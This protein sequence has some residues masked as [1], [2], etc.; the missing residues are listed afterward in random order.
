MAPHTCHEDGDTL[1]S[2]HFLYLKAALSVFY[3]CYSNCWLMLYLLVK[4]KQQL[5]GYSL[6]SYSNHNKIFLRSQTVT[7]AVFFL[8]EGKRS[9]HGFHPVNTF[10]KEPKF[11]AE[12]QLCQSLKRIFLT[13]S[14]CLTVFFHMLFL[15][16]FF[17]FLCYMKTNQ[18]IMMIVFPV[19]RPYNTQKWCFKARID[20]MGGSSEV[21]TCLTLQKSMSACDIFTS[22]LQGLGPDKQP[23]VHT[24][25]F[26]LHKQLS[27]SFL[28][29]QHVILRKTIA[30]NKC[31]HT[32]YDLF[33]LYLSSASYTKT[34]FHCSR[35]HI[36]PFWQL[37]FE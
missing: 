16:Y 20:A 13:A 9:Q 18:I 25:I 2:K 4:G 36:I 6:L 19:R 24:F 28:V 32:V 7:I 37:M 29:P 21:K 17:R 5:P 3:T 33:H 11:K 15:P 23:W 12:V 1:R 34:T 26:D 22:E 8:S 27:L 35:L 10:V 30:N 14:V 31:V